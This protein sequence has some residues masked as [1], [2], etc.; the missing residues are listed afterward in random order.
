MFVKK[1]VLILFLFI[2]LVSSYPN[3]SSLQE[4]QGEPGF[5]AFAQFPGPPTQE[6]SGYAQFYQANPTDC[7]LQVQWNSGFT[8]SSPSAYTFFIG[9]NDVT[10]AIRAKLVIRNRGTQGINVTFKSFTCESVVGTHFIVKRT[11][12]TTTKIIADAIIHS[13]FD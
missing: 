2:V 13:L 7:N 6:A 1:S 10:T 4:R 12:G 9:P 8:S 11:I 5:V 3:P